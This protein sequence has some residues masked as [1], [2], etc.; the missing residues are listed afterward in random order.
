MRILLVAAALLSVG[1]ASGGRR[2]PRF[3]HRES[4]RLRRRPV[5]RERGAVRQAGCERLLPG[6]ELFAGGIVPQGRPGRGYRRQRGA[7]PAAVQSA[8]IG[9]RSSA[10]AE[11]S[12]VRPSQGAPGV[13]AAGA[14]RVAR[15]ADFSHP[16]G[17]HGR[18]PCDD[19]RDHSQERR[20]RRARPQ[21]RAAQARR[22]P[23][24]PAQRGREPRLAGALAHLCRTATASACPEWRILVTLGQFETMTGKAIG[25][26]SH[27]HKTKVL[28]RR[29]R[30]RRAQAGACGAKTAPTG[31]KAFLSLTPAG[32]AIYRGSR[33]GRARLRADA[34]SKRST[35]RP[36]RLRAGSARIDRTIGRA[37]GPRPIAPSRSPRE[38]G[39]CHARI[40]VKLYSYFRSSAAYR[41]ASRSISRAWPTRP[42]RST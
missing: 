11:L 9:S 12:A 13:P 2:T 19:R 1:A 40:P 37:R 26:H 33:A 6:A 14:A 38:R 32:R 24:V 23:A 28:A 35:R 31:A 29:P 25:A 18:G 22:V 42:C 21:R 4:R 15:R 8:A 10:R 16:C 30:A 17:R 7:P 27:M 3:H 36:R 34:C 20:L 39:V 41:R 5:P